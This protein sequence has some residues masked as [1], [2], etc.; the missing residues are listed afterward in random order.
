M[1]EA[2]INKG[3]AAIGQPR[4]ENSPIVV[5]G[6]ARGGT[7]MLAGA[8]AK[9][10]VFMGERAVPPVY[11]DV[12]LSTAFEDRDHDQVSRIVNEYGKN[13]A[14]WGW[15][16]PSAIAYLDDVERL[17]PEPSYIF[18]FK[19]IFS[20]AQRNSISMLSEFLPGME[21]ALDQYCLALK[22]LRQNTPPAL[23]VSYDKA[24]SYPEHLVDTLIQTYRI[25]ATEQQRKEAID[26]IR[27][28]PMDYLDA[29]R[30]T[31]AQGRL[32]GVSQRKIF[33]WARYIHAKKT[34]EV[35]IFLNEKS[36]G[37]TLANCPSDEL[38]EKFGEPC[39][40]SY[41]LPNH[42][43]L[44][45][46]DILR[47]RVIN[48]VEDLENSPLTYVDEGSSV[49][50]EGVSLPSS[51][52]APA[53]GSKRRYSDDLSCPCWRLVRGNVEQ[54]QL[55]TD[56]LQRGKQPA[57]ETLGSGWQPSSVWQIETGL[58]ILVLK[59]SNNQRALWYFDA[60]NRFIG[61]SAETVW[62]LGSW[63][64]ES[65]EVLFKRLILECVDPA[66]HEPH[67]MSEGIEPLSGEFS[68]LANDL[69]ATAR[70]LTGDRE[71]PEGQILNASP[72]EVQDEVLEDAEGKMNVLWRGKKL[73]AARGIVVS[74]FIFAYPLFENKSLSALVFV[75]SHNGTRTAF[76]DMADMKLFYRKVAVVESPNL[77]LDLLVHLKAHWRELREYFR[78]AELAP[79]VGVTRSGH[80][81]H[82][83]WNEL[84]GLHR[85]RRN[86]GLMRLRELIHFDPHNV[87]EVWIGAREVL[88]W[89]NLN[90]S[91]IGPNNGNISKWVYD[92]RVFP[93]RIG[94]SYIPK[95]LADLVASHC[96]E[97][98]EEQVPV[99]VPGELRIVFGLRFEN[100]TWVNQSE[101]L[102]EL[103]CHLAKRFQKLTIIIDGHD[104]I[105]KRK[106]LSHGEQLAD[107]DIVALEKDVVRVV[108]A[109]IADQKDAG[110]VTIVD[111]VDMEL[112]DTMA[113]I[114]SADC[115]VA[116][117]GAGLAK[118]KWVA[119][120]DGVIFSSREVIE[121][122]PG[123]KIYEDSKIR[124]GATECIYLS[125]EYVVKN[126]EGSRLINIA[127]EDATRDNFLVDMTGL[128]A[129]VD[130]LV[131]LVKG[132][133]Q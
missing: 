42:I 60:E 81:G 87:G 130:K 99:K 82:R 119:N 23:M 33:G 49:D 52:A 67:L 26:F 108:K 37:V 91:L 2:L 89:P 50:S 123:L 66:H 100:R 88:Q 5:V 57:V 131:Q 32:G 90:V 97:G 8:L 85:I 59:N 79:V 10:G 31:K 63:V 109:A 125:P 9:L 39:A 78:D 101:G 56:S 29:S 74:N 35:E 80:I 43:T 132:E 19:D 45:S 105:Q 83:L 46:G 64:R 53:V 92:N 54:C 110:R 121:T 93:L 18:I 122:K 7:S 77:L 65:F 70:D 112:Y 69:F 30:I 36:I 128:K 106:A 116:P 25:K 114:L 28:N 55:N 127:R 15:K 16:R 4:T 115:F 17:L 96:L 113:W 24:V 107:G 38:L 61:N 126:A 72:A 117:W 118:Y 41:E 3:V 47:A 13:Y 124:E 6:T 84:T 48:E 14:R 86:E 1:T 102:A 62:G 75:G 21:K 34:A 94:D 27:P 68:V 58:Q 104:R 76:L 120:L 103:A 20:I 111:A 98:A 129:T 11:E 22:F 40:Y 71:S 95:S 44:K 51:G 73:T 12:H 133:G